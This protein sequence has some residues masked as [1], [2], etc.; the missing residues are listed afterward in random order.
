MKI[1]KRMYEIMEAAIPGDVPS[2]VF[3]VFIVTLISLNVCAVVLQTVSDLRVQYAEFFTNFELL[4]LIIFTIEYVLRVTFCTADERYGH[5][6][7]GRLRFMTTPVVVIDLLAILPFYLPFIGMDLRW[8]RIFR[9]LRILRIMKLGRYLRSLRLIWNVMSEKRVELTMTA[10]LLLLLLVMASS[11]MFA[12]ENKAQPDKFT[13]IPTTM[14]WAVDILTNRARHAEIAP[15]TVA[16]RLLEIVIAVLAIGTFALPTA[17]LG[18]GFIDAFR[19]QRAEETAKC[20]HC[21]R[22]LG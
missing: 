8:V 16:G 18:S 7:F 5:P 19:K 13:D 12:I 3:D 10:A 14:W 11:L 4:S 17:I 22:Y 1:R 6:L 21:G 2:K 9:L 15:V 20:P